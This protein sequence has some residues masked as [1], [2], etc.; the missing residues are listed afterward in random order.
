MR[1][2]PGWKHIVLLAAPLALGVAAVAGASL[3]ASTAPSTTNPQSIPATATQDIPPATGLL[4]HVSGAVAKPGL[5]RLPRR[6]RV[7]DAISAAGGLLL[8]AD[9]TLLPNPAC[10]LLDRAQVQVVFAKA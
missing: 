6:D 4:V 10:Q 8:A 2:I 7:Y 9:P 5:Y 3:Y 1:L